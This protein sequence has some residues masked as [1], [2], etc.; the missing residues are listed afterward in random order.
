MMTWLAIGILVLTAVI[1]G[2]A[3]MS[4][5][6]RRQDADLRR[7]LLHDRASAAPGTFDPAILDGLPEPARRF[8]RFAIAEGAPL[9]RVAEI[10]MD[11]ELALGEP[12]RA[13]PMRMRARQTLAAPAGFLWEVRARRGLM[14]LSGS[15]A[16]GFGRSW[17]RFRLFGFLAVARAGGT[18]DHARS[19]FGRMI[20]EALFW[21]PAAL[22]P[23]P[24]TCWEAAGPD[25]ARVT[26]G[27]GELTQAV[28]VTVDAEGRPTDVLF[29]RWSDANPGRAFR[30]QP[31]GG[32]LADFRDFGGFRLPTSVEAGN[33]YGTP[34]YFPFFRARVTGVRFPPDMTD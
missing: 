29:Q 24:G 26:V 22:L 34:D 15:D 3:G 31:F 17:S 2:L 13:K 1:G 10:E 19:A 11:G 25:T 23:G 6:D 20:A 32:K 33:F 4:V 12:G 14:R 27:H 18:D 9:W 16:F 8:F 5:R 30:L 28:D 21:T 7:A